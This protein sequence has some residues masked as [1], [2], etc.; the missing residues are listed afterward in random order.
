MGLLIELA[1]HPLDRRDQRVVD[2]QGRCDVNRGR[3]GVV[4]GLPQVDVI[5]GMHVGTRLLCQRRDD[6][7]GVHVAGGA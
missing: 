7:I 5:V 1:G 6:L 2:L 4:A 3:K